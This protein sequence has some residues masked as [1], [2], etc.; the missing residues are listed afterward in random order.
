MYFSSF[1][2]LF[3]F[4][5]GIVF[6]GSLTKPIRTLFA[7]IAIVAPLEGWT[8]YLNLTSQNNLMYFNI[9]TLIGFVFLSLIFGQ[10]IPNRYLKWSIGLISST[11]WAY[12]VVYFFSRDL[13]IF[14]T[15]L[16]VIE[17]FVFIGYS[18]LFIVFSIMRTK[19]PYLERNPYFLLVGGL[20]I[21]FSGTVFVFLFGDY[22]SENNF[23]PAWTVHSLLNIFLNLTY[24][25]VIWKSKRISST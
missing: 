25:V 7:F 1:S 17:C 5:L 21:Y 15:K 9:V 14:H 16:R 18:I 23:M 8:L 20:L 6:Y 10:M 22:L 3:P 11:V 13:D 19:I 4:L 24:F 2:I 12:F